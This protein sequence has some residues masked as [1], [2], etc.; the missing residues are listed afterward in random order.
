MSF[1]RR[2]AHAALVPA[3]A[4][5]P[6]AGA[7]RDAGASSP[8]ASPASEFGPETAAIPPAVTGSPLALETFT[9][10]AVH[11]AAETGPNAPPG[12]GSE[13]ARI[14]LQSLTVP[15]WGQATLGHDTA[16]IVF[17][18]IEAGIW[19]SF[20]AFKLQQAMR[21]D[22]NVRTATVYA[23]I[24]LSGRDES[25][26]R[27]VGQYP[28]SDDYNL[29]VV[30][31]DAANLYYGDPAAMTA[32]IN[33]HVLSGAESWTWPSPESYQLY[34]DQRKSAQRAGLR[35]NTALALAVANRIVSALHAARYA[36]APRGHA[37]EIE[38]GPTGADLSGGR[39]A[40]TTRF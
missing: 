15:G 32:Y 18:T 31:R 14:L 24:D 4:L 37:L 35:A 9:P 27:I 19:T 12:L 7:I 25:F 30:Y 11:D 16:A 5:L 1:I 28:N 22:S 10:A 34:Q 2:A 21:T 33:T 29:Y 36:G 38:M 6:V 20:A 13:R 8:V 40:L 26:R 17:A 23:G 39:V 3:L